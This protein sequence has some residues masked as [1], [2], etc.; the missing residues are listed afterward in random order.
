MILSSTHNFEFF[1]AGI[2]QNFLF[3]KYRRMSFP[4]YMDIK[5]ICPPN[6]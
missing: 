2:G 4:A 5:S 3:K 6:L 1:E